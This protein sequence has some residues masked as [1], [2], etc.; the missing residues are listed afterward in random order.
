MYVDVNLYYGGSCKGR[1]A[2]ITARHY[3]FVLSGNIID[4]QDKG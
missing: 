4:I 2:P 1:H 3:E